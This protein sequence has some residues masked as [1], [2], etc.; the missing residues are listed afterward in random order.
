MLKAKLK[1]GEIKAVESDKG[2]KI[3]N[4]KDKQNVVTLSTVPEHDDTL[5]DTGRVSRANELIKKTQSVLDY[6]KCKKG[7]DL[8]DQMPSYYL[9]LKKTR[10]WY[11]KVA[12]E[13]IAGTSVVNAWVLYNQYYAAKTMSIRNFRESIVLASTRGINEEVSKP[14]KSSLNI[15]GTLSSE[16]F[17]VEVE[18]SKWQSRKGYDKMLTAFEGSKVARNKARKISTFFNACEGSPYLCIPCFNMKHG[19]EY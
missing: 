18:G 13:V 14:G 15:L 8:S 9:L 10:K 7:I 19:A 6:D 2:V 3:F 16:H 1:R 11:K 4:W 5:V 17:L 12:F